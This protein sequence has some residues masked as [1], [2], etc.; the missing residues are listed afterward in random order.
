M[1]LPSRK[2]DMAKTDVKAGGDGGCQLKS[3]GGGYAESSETQ[4]T[5]R[6][7]DQE[8]EIAGGEPK[9][10][11]RCKTL[12]WTT[13]S[14]DL[15]VLTE[16]NKSFCLWREKERELEIDLKKEDFHGTTLG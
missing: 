12:K 5:R 10:E 14:T 3:R 13:V 2:G 15:L 4:G 9:V 16:S 6:R 1:H 8:D 11:Q 7:L